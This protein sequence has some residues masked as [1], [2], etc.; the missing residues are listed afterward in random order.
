[1]TARTLT[2][3]A[4]A[5]LALAAAALPTSGDRRWRGLRPPRDLLAAATGRLPGRLV[6]VLAW[7]WLGCHLLAR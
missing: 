7:A 5:A 6:V 2:L 3:V 4:L 1:M